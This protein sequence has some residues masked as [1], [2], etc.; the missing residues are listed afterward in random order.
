MRSELVDLHRKEVE[1]LVPKTLL[2]SQRLNSWRGEEIVQHRNPVIQRSSTFVAHSHPVS[3]TNSFSLAFQERSRNSVRTIEGDRNMS[4]TE[5]DSS[6]TEHSG[7]FEDFSFESC[8][9]GS[10]DRLRSDASLSQDTVPVNRR[11]LNCPS[12]INLWRPRNDEKFICSFAV[13]AWFSS[14]SPEEDLKRAPGKKRRWFSNPLHSQ[15]LNRTDSDHMEFNTVSRDTSKEPSD[16][17]YASRLSFGRVASRPKSA[18]GVLFPRALSMPL[19]NENNSRKTCHVLLT[20]QRLIGLN[21]LE[22]GFGGGMQLS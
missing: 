18:D 16:T 22:M 13:A 6:S 3:L 4:S 2:L 9:R 12:R 19:P 17:K 15:T 11:V 20:T 7:I 10:E 8:L 5:Q 21:E 1:E 14:I